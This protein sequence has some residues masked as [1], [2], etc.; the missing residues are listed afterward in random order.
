MLMLVWTIFQI[1]VSS[2][3]WFPLVLLVLSFLRKKQTPLNA[4]VQELDFAIIVTAYQQ[5]D[6]LADAVYSILKTK[7][8]NFIVYVVADNCDVSALNFD[9]Q[10]VV[11]LRPENTLAS[12]VKS[13]IYAIDRFKRSHDI[14]T[15]V[16]SDNLVDANYLHALNL[17]FRENFSAVQGVRT[18]RNLNTFLACLDEAGDM[19]YRYIDRKL[20]AESGSSASLAGS[21]MAFKSDLYI[22]ALKDIE[23]NGA[24]FDK[25]LQ[26]KLVVGKEKIAFCEDAIVYDAKTAKAD[27][28]V[29][30]RS[31]WINTWFKYWKL[32]VI[33]LF[34]SI[35]NFNWNQFAFSVMLLRPPLFLLAFIS[36]IVMLLNLFFSPFLLIIWLVSFLCFFAMFYRSLIYFNADNVI[37]QSLWSAPKFMFYQMVSLFKARSANKISVATKHDVSNL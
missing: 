30:Q 18:A 35:I 19:F 2:F 14:I 34:K 21:G 8:S 25:A 29:K 24:G 17:K 27:Q 5:I 9:N 31:R 22:N 11:L 23:T 13:H 33:L 15:I 7:Y 6:L 10:K 12:N 4:G 20:L 36:T 26:Y 37:Y 16:D 3:L 1:L 28:L 32:G